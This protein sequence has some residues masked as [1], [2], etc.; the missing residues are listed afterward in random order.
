MVWFHS[1]RP[2]PRHTL[3]YWLSRELVPGPNTG[4]SSQGRAKLRVFCVIIYIVEN[5][6]LSPSMTRKPGK[7]SIVNSS[8]PFCLCCGNPALEKSPMSSKFIAFCFA[9][10]LLLY[11]GSMNW[12][13]FPPLS[14]PGLSFTLLNSYRTVKRYTL[15]VINDKKLLP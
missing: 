11:C 2:Q 6:Q 5:T 9:S 15:N 7:T 12:I 13:H 4:F 3:S 10:L 14:F 8:C 1:G